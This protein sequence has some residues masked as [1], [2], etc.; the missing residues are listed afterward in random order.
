MYP[1]F[2]K[3]IF[4]VI[5]E[6]PYI[7]VHGE[8]SFVMLVSY[9][10]SN[11]SKSSVLWLGEGLK[12]SI[13]NLYYTASAC[14]L[15]VVL[16]SVR[17]CP[18]SRP[19]YICPVRLS[20]VIF[21]VVYGRQ[22]QSCEFHRSSLRLWLVCPAYR[23]TNFLVYLFLIMYMTFVLSPT[24]MLVFLSLYIIMWCWAYFFPFWHVRPQVCSIGLFG[25]CTAICT[26]Y[27]ITGSTY[28]L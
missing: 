13:G 11:L 1:Q 24:E 14:R 20:T 7:L 19:L 2:Y 3:V 26:I 17:S 4:I 5:I 6:Q 23:T 22:V 12:Y 28:E 8:H 21:L 25:E 27:V 16:S 15:H 10:T 9:D 18:S